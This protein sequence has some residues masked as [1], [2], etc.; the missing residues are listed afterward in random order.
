MSY[1]A[2]IVKF[3]KEK[4]GLTQ[5]QLAEKMGVN[6]STLCTVERDYRRTSLQF[7]EKIAKVGNCHVSEVLGY[8]LKQTK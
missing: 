8:G 2:T 4:L 3:R 1:G 7:F 5:E 6:V